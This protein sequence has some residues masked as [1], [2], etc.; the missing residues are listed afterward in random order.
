MVYNQEVGSAMDNHPL[1]GKK[2]NGFKDLHLCGG[3]LILLYRYDVEEDA[4]I[5]SAKLRNIIN[6]DELD[7]PEMYSEPQWI[8]VTLED[9]KK[10]I[11]GSVQIGSDFDKSDIIE[12]FFEYYNYNIAK[13][14]P[15]DEIYPVDIVTSDSQIVIMVMMMNLQ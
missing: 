10:T 7:R 2:T 12:W 4:L 6:H 1:S 11:K 9:V 13:I 3:D 8:E 5:V 15:I 14:L